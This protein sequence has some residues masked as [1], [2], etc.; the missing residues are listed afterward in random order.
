MERSSERI[1]TTHVGALQ[2]PADLAQT[3]LHKSED[4]PEARAMLKTAVADIVRHQVET[5]FDVVNDGEFDKTLWMWYVRDRLGGI[6]SRYWSQAEEAYLKGRDREG[7]DEFYSWAD[8]N[9]NLFGY[10]EDA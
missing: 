7:F 6:D 5:G 10:M 9:Q 3:M 1:L 8:A 2:R 4:S